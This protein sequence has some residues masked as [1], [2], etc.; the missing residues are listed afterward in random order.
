MKDEKTKQ[1][2][3]ELRADGWSYQRIAAELK[4]GKQT[5]IN[6][7]K[8]LR[9]EIANLRAI[10]MEALQEQYGALVTHRI[11]LFGEKLRALE[12]ELDTRDLSELPTEKLLNLM[13][14]YAQA[15]GREAINLSFEGET[16]F[17]G[18]LDCV[19]TWVA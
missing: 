10:Q 11:R 9:H 3:L 4:V 7:S 2:F 14:K 17:L 15:L 13:L 18:D 19:E 16:V 5:L 1:Q 8:E 6:W 12:R